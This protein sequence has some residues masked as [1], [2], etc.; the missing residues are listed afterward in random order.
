MRES[1]IANMDMKAKKRGLVAEITEQQQKNWTGVNRKG[2][3]RV[4]EQN[5][6]EELYHFKISDDYKILYLDVSKEILNSQSTFT[7]K[8][9]LTYDFDI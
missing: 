4:I 2:Y 8:M 3:K 9:E 1:D 7:A 6:D 5:K